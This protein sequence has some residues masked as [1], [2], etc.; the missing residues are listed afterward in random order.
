LKRVALLCATLITIPLFANSYQ[1]NVVIYGTIF[2]LYKDALFRDQYEIVYLIYADGTIL[3]FTI[4]DP[5]Y[6]LFPNNDMLEKYKK[7]F[8]DALVIVHN[9]FASPR[10]SSQDENLLRWLRS[11]GFN[12][13]FGIYVMAL[14]KFIPHKD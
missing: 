1:G 5:H 10:F 4:K 6:F 13:I 14:N 12:G 9:H 3:G 8:Q 2:N 7:R 11:N